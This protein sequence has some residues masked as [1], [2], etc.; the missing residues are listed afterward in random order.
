[1]T[2]RELKELLIEL[3]DDQLNMDF[4]VALTPED[5]WFKVTKFAI[6]RPDAWDVLDADHPYFIVDTQ[7]E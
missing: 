7:G 6:T 2:Y 1:M 3:S 5:E 4:T